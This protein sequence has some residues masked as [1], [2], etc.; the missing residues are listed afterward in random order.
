MN[1]SYAGDQ[2]NVLFEAD[3]NGNATGCEAEEGLYI[4]YADYARLK[5][6]VERLT[7][8]IESSNYYFLSI[9][10]KAEVCNLNSALQEGGELVV[11]MSDK[12]S[13]LKAEVER[14]KAEPDALTAYLYADTLRR[15]DIKTMKAHIDRLTKAGDYLSEHLEHEFGDNPSSKLWNAAKLGGQP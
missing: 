2:W 14:L 4:R 13:S 15:D 6:E 1:C 5:V 9:K 3:K 7:K 10:L 12:I 11:K 8:E